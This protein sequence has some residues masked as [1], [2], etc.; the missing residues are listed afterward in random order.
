[1]PY[2]MP[3]L[4]LWA[5]LLGGSLIALSGCREPENVGDD[6]IPG[7]TVY[8]FQVDAQEH[9]K[10]RNLVYDTIRTDEP[11]LFIF[12]EYYDPLFGTT[13]ARTNIQLLPEEGDLPGRG[14]PWRFDSLKLQL[15][16]LAF[17]GETSEPMTWEVY[18]LDEILEQD[19]A[20]YSNREAATQPTNLLPSNRIVYSEDDSVFNTRIDFTMPQEMGERLLALDETTLDDPDAFKQVLPGFQIRARRLADAT[21]GIIYYPEFQDDNTHLRLYYTELSDSGEVNHTY[22]FRLDAQTAG[23]NYFERTNSDGTLFANTIAQPADEQAYLFA[24]GA[25]K[26]VIGGEIQQALIDSL[27]GRS[28]THVFLELPVIEA[29][30]Q[31]DDNYLQP[32]SLEFRLAEDSTYEDFDSPALARIEGRYAE[33]DS[34]YRFPI[35][36]IVQGLNQSWVDQRYFTLTARQPSTSFRRAIF[37]SNAHPTRKPQIKVY[38]APLPNVEAE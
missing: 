38:Y 9:I 23:Y 33:S 28:A 3:R 22:D 12:G 29:Y 36:G 37:G 15:N 31:N 32:T 30:N 25:T 35:T 7:S 6:L 4:W 11:S 20:Y 17:I 13:I 18:E 5:A 24:Q 34:V 1:M 16:V 19:D 27:E 2:T 26:V 21:N 10:L 14:S 8:S